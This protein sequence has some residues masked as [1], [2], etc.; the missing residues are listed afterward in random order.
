MF[1]KSIGFSVVEISHKRVDRPNPSVYYNHI[2]NHCEMLLFVTGKATYNIDGQMFTPSPYDLLFIPAAKYHYLMPTDSVPYEN[3]VIG[4]DPRIVQSEHYKNLFASPLMLNIKNDSKLLDF[5]STLDFYERNY[6]EKDFA[7]CARAIVSE[8]ITYCNYR[9][10]SLISYHGE[11]LMLIEKIIAFIDQNIEKPLDA[12]VIASHF[13]FSKSYIQ[14]TFSNHMHIGLKK[15]IMQ[16]KIYS[17]Y[18]DLSC[19]MTP[20]DVCEKYSF[21]DYSSFYR[22]YKS[23]FGIAPSTNKQKPAD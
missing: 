3:Y 12:D 4:I 11:S 23:I 13:S 15:Y 5:F 17:A 16:K 10:D 8:I 18:V 7:V 6:S 14:N 19:G 1:Q 2:H 22:L 20:N 21:G 9:K